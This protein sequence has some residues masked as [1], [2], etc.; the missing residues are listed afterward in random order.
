MDSARFWFC[1]LCCSALLP[2][3]WRDLADRRRGVSK[4]GWEIAGRAAES[5]ELGEL[6]GAGWEPFAVSESGGGPQ[7]VWVRK[8]TKGK[9]DHGVAKQVKS[10]GTDRP[11]A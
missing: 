2:S 1:G 4:K 9:R 3:V 5:S 7:T 8:K 10:A 6:L 11:V